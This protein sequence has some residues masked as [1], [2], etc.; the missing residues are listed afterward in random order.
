M[1]FGLVRGPKTK[2]RDRLSFIFAVSVLQEAQQWNLKLKTFLYIY[3]TTIVWNLFFNI[4]ITH[5]N[6]LNK[7]ISCTFVLKQVYLYY[8]AA[9]TFRINESAL[10][11]K[12]QNSVISMNEFILFKQFTFLF[13]RTFSFGIFKSRICINITH[14]QILHIRHETWHFLPVSAVSLSYFIIS[15]TKSDLRVEAHKCVT[16]AEGEEMKK[17]IRAVSYVECSSKYQWNVDKV[18]ETAMLSVFRQERPKKRHN[19]SCSIFWLYTLLV[20]RGRLSLVADWL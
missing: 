15:G 9:L 2:H 1:H 20:S 6:L 3:M 4:Y 18:F 13:S 5:R 10:Y 11:N 7:M 17:M 14:K 19:N 12:N 16:T 8:R